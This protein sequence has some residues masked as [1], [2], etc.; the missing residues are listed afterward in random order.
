MSVLMSVLNYAVNDYSFYNSVIC[1]VI[2]ILDIRGRGVYVPL[3][4]RPMLGMG[5]SNYIILLTGD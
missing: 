1:L 5:L 4:R 3:S 2:T